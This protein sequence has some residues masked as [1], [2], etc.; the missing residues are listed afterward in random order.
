MTRPDLK[1]VI[2]ISAP[3]GP[4][5]SFNSE[6][7]LRIAVTKM[8]ADS[9]QNIADRRGTTSAH[10]TPERCL[11]KSTTSA[12]RGTPRPVDPADVRLQMW[13]SRLASR[14]DRAGEYRTRLTRK[15]R[16]VCPAAQSKKVADG[17]RWAASGH[18]KRQGEMKPPPSGGRGA[19]RFR[20]AASKL[21]VSCA[22]DTPT[23]AYSHN[24]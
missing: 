14:E 3:R 15:G 21:P 2:G 23:A 19:D 20:Q 6:C 1:S 4:A 22:R 16:F 24:G 9:A 18:A 12:C 11:R 7:G 17:C 10:R 13:M 5:G 8:P